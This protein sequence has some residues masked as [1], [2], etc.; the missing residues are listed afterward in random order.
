MAHREGGVVGLMD[1]LDIAP[2]EA[3]LAALSPRWDVAYDQREHQGGWYCFAVGTRRPVPTLTFT[4]ANEEVRAYHAAMA[5]PLA[6][7]A[8]IAAAPDDV[9]AL[10]AEVKRLRAR[11]LG[12]VPDV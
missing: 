4:S 11:L 1:A 9:R 5:A 8:F 3:R 10:L 7:V 2:I 12:E 6:D